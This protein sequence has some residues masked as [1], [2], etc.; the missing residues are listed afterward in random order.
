M[1]YCWLQDSPFPSGNLRVRVG[2]P[3]SEEW[4]R[5]W[6]I[7]TIAPIEALV[8]AFL[9]PGNQDVVNS[10]LTNGIKGYRIWDGL[11]RTLT[12]ISSLCRSSWRHLHHLHQCLNFDY[13]LPQLI[14]GEQ[15]QLF[16]LTVS[17]SVC[18][19][20]HAL[21]E[22]ET[23][24]ASSLRLFFRLPPLGRIYFIR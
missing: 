19:L 13:C 1:R 4:T 14:W 12:T 6:T 7:P 21:L 11:L 5:R 18:A 8:S 17:R 2:R 10:C 16:K 20:C 3:A 9:W 24:S 23:G 15:P 22:C